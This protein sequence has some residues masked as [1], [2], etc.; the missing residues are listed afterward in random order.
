LD[1]QSKH[2][3][4]LGYSNLHKG[5]KY[6][7]ISTGRMYISRDIV[8][9]ETIFPFFSLHSNAGARLRDEISLL[10]LSLQHLN[11]QYHEGLELR[12][13]FDVNPANATNSAAE[14]FLQNSD[15]NFHSD[16]ESGNSANFG[17]DSSDR[18]G[19]GT[20]SHPVSGSLAASGSPAAWV[21]SDT[22][23]ACRVIVWHG[24]IRCPL[25]AGPAVLYW[26]PGL[27]SSTHG[28]ST[29]GSMAIDRTTG[30]AV[31]LP[32]LF[33]SGSDAT[34]SSGS[35]PGSGAAVSCGCSSI[36]A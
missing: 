17:A 11:L 13:P 23:T 12:E 18:P 7:D 22:V 16:D 2:Y 5:Y 21:D 27:T 36:V 8:F 20:P 6:L 28:S 24:R 14:S 26:M 1:F 19:A 29:H 25:L 34:S 35:L 4:F 10:P 3:A 32:D 15:H 31:L 33:A 30:Y 9:Y